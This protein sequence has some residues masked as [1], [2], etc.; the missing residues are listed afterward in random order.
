MRNNKVKH[1]ALSDGK[2]LESTLEAIS[3]QSRRKREWVGWD[4]N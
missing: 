2:F 4:G 3:F 1:F